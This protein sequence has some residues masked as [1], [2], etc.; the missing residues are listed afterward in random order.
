MD[1]PVDAELG[2]HLIHHLVEAD[3]DV[4]HIR[5][6]NEE[7]EGAL[8]PLEV[9]ER[10][11]ARG[12]ITLQKFEEIKTSLGQEDPRELEDTLQGPSRS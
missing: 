5:Y 4:G 7:Y 3:F 9:A 8:G 6:Q 12:D 10:R 2:L 1:V 11:C